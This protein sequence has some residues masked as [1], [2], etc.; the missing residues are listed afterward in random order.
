MSKMKDRQPAIKVK[1]LSKV[2]C[3]VGWHKWIDMDCLRM[4]SSR[5][6]VIR[7]CTRCNKKQEG[8]YDMFMGCMHW[9]DKG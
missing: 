3:Y 9:V 4:T 2:L 6:Q 7:V 1:L 8:V 5:P